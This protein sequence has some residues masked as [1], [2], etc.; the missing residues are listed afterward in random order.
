MKARYEN[1]AMVPVPESEWRPKTDPVREALF[2]D[3]KARG[4]VISGEHGIGLVKKRYLSFVLSER[5]IEIMRGIKKAF[6]PRGIMN[7][8]K[9]FD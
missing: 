7:P 5:E 2:R 1:G 6:D 4:G 3:A 9:I 8:G